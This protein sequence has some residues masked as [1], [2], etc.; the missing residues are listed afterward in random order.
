M[1]VAAGQGAEL[2][3]RWLC[4]AVRRRR[5]L[6][7]AMWPIVIYC[8]IGMAIDPVRLGIAVFLMSRRQPIMNLFAFWLGGMVAGIGVA[9]VVLILLR[10]MALIAIQ[11][12]AGVV[13][14]VR[15]AVVILSGGGLQ[16]T[17][18]LVALLSVGIVMARQRGRVATPAVA[19]A[20]A[21]D[22]VPQSSTPTIFARLAA[23]SQDLLQ[24]GFFWPAFVVGLATSFPVIDGVVV[25]TV[26]MASGASL[27]SQFS[28]FVLFTVILLAVIEVPLI[29]YMLVPQRT[30]A[31]MLAIQQWVRT[32]RRQISQTMV[33]VVGVI[34]LAQGI[35]RL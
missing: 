29:G 18:G 6:L 1:R 15:S 14:D 22:V 10:D 32:Y 12:A 24:A 33:V 16:I 13:N 19:G 26:I 3:M 28:A 9:T 4:H 30:E 31:V 27:G 5:V 8:A 35:A 2:A 20:G 11:N 25:L 17:V 23:R 7:V 21:S 34:F